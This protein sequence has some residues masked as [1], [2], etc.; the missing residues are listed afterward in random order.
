MEHIS[1]ELLG[2]IK[3]FAGKD[4]RFDGLE[5]NADK[6]QPSALKR[7]ISA[8]LASIAQKKVQIRDTILQEFSVDA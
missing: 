5:I 7:E 1:P 8:Y 3:K 2:E 6:I 4:T